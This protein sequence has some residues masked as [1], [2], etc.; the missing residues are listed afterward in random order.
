MMQNPEA[1]S[2]KTAARQAA[3]GLEQEKP[4][5]WLERL[6]L[7]PVLMVVATLTFGVKIGNIWDDAD[8]FVAGVSP[9][10]AEDAVADEQPAAEGSA[11][12]EP[13]TEGE[14]VAD[15]SHDQADAADDAEWDASQPYSR[16]ELQLL[17][18]LSD[19]RA[20][21]D[22]RAKAID[23]RERVLD[24]MEQRIDGKIGEM[25][26]IEAQVQAYLKSY[27]EK[28]IQNMQSLVKMYESMKPKDAA[29][30]LEQLQMDVLLEVATNMKERQMASIMAEM[31]P[32][33]AKALTMEMATRKPIPL[34]SN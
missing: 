6:R 24:A 7:L 5:R 14:A 9:A 26:S 18:N 27:D 12:A 4:G 15:E 19:R 13:G 25:K 16:G 21:L 20:E 23:M 30:I 32:D 2:R 10:M 29:R 3:A 28:H 11:A 31:S 22:K 8:D 17:V 34:A 33:S 1:T